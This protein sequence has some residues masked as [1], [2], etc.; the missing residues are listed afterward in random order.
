MKYRSVYNIIILIEKISRIHIQ[1]ILYI[2]PLT[3]LYNFKI[4]FLTSFFIK[5]QI[6]SYKY[7]ISIK[8]MSVSNINNDCHENLG[9]HWVEDV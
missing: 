8:P 1:H 5:E 2:I 7:Y 6:Q 4:R 3:Y 9:G